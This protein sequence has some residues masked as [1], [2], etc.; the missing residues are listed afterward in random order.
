MNLHLCFASYA[1]LC[2]FIGIYHK[3]VY[4]VM[5]EGGGWVSSCLYEQRGLQSYCIWSC[6]LLMT[7]VNVEMKTGR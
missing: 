3:Q 4:V 1:N 7:Y 2:I 6:G 5:N